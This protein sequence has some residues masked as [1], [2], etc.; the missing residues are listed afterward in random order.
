MGSRLGQW[1][2]NATLA[3]AHP[4]LM[5]AFRR[6][7][8]YWPSIAL[9]S[10]I[11][12]KFLWRKI[13]DRDPR[14]FVLSDKLATKQLMAREH[15]DIKTAKVLWQGDDIRQAPAAL[16]S[17][18]GFLKAN[19]ASGFNH[20]LGRTENPPDIAALHELTRKWLSTRW[21]RYH[22][23]WGYSGVPARLFIEE[24]VSLTGAEN[25]VDLTMYMFSG[26]VSHLAVMVNHKSSRSHV[27]RFDEFGQRLSIPT[28]ANPGRKPQ[29]LLAPPGD[30]E[31][32]PMDYKLPH[33]T[34]AM[35]E[36]ARE[37]SRDFD[38]VRVD[39]L[40][41]GKDWYLT[42]LTLYSMGGYIAYSDKDLL[43][44]MTA[45][46]SLENSWLLTRPQRG[47]RSAYARWLRR[48]LERGRP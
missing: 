16:L 46:W 1:F 27:A 9:P 7:S 43:K 3:L 44:R 35:V 40:W 33:G 19:H 29:P 18:P 26:Q 36:R 42:E 15:P 41:N 21:E 2:W 48:R 14:F 37:L 4:R 28:P 45:L 39:L 32:L 47:W 23:E 22:G 5:L 25:N 34:L 6:R 30:I 8:G 38:H 10:S 17:A 11:D 24:D 20:R 12:E 31:I 13:I